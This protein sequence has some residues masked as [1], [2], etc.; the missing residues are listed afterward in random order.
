[1]QI[2]IDIPDRDLKSCTAT[3]FLV[4]ATLIIY[5]MLTGVAGPAAAKGSE[6]DTTYPSKPLLSAYITKKSPARECAAGSSRDAFHAVEVSMHKALSLLFESLVAQGECP[7]RS[8]DVTTVIT[9]SLP[10]VLS[11][12]R[13]VKADSLTIRKVF[14]GFDDLHHLYPVVDSIPEYKRAE[15]FVAVQ[16]LVTI[17]ADW[18]CG[19]YGDA[20]SDSE[21]WSLVQTAR[22]SAN[23]ALVSELREW[24]ADLRVVLQRPFDLRSPDCL[25]RSIAWRSLPDLNPVLVGRVHQPDV[26]DGVQHHPPHS[27][28][29]RGARFRDGLRLLSNQLA[30]KHN[31]LWSQYTDDNR[32][33]V[34][35]M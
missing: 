4:A 19:A 34:G 15:L 18:S 35:V 21:I 32:V 2:H 20:P 30:R 10:D 23:G 1:M 11:W 27:R 12:L 9:A 17:L 31:Q 3:S 25:R 24:D 13:R 26:R 22:W 33:T 14:V 16:T 8:A 28:D 7:L 29:S 6:C 5:I